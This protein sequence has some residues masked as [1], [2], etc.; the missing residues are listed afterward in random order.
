MAMRIRAI[1]TIGPPARLMMGIMTGKMEAMKET[2]IDIM[3][4]NG[5]PC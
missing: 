2:T 4:R 3:V 1:T 5:A